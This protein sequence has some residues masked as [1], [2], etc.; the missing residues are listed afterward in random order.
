VKYDTCVPKLI[1]GDVELGNFVLG[2]PD[3]QAKTDFEASRR[4]L[5]EVEGLPLRL[6][7]AID[8]A[9]AYSAGAQGYFGA[10][11]DTDTDHGSHAGS[12]DCG[13]RYLASNG[14][15]IYI[16]LNHLELATPEVLS[17]HEYQALWMA[18]LR[19]AAQAQA[20][21][22]AALPEGQRIVVLA[23]NSDRQDNSYGGHQSFLI[24]RTAWDDMIRQRMLPS[25]FNLMAFQVSSIVYTGQGKVGSENG[26]SPVPFQIAQR[27]DFIETLLGEQTTYHRPLVNT[28]DEPL[29]G[30][31]SWPSALGTRGD[32]YAR[33]HVIFFDT[34]LAPVATF[35]KCGVMQLILTLIEAQRLGESLVL[36][37]PL[38]ALHC[39][40][41]DPDLTVRMPLASGRRVSAVELQMLFLEQAS[42]FEREGGFEGLVPGSARILELWADT[43]CKLE[44]SAFDDLRG[45]LDWVMKRSLIEHS[46]AEHNDWTWESPQVRHLDQVYASLDPRESLFYALDAAGAF[47]RVASAT[48]IAHYTSHPPA[49]TRAWTRAMLLRALPAELIAHVDWDRIDLHLSSNPRDCIRLALADPLGGTRAATQAIFA[50]ELALPNLLM[51]LQQTG[52]IGISTFQARAVAPESHGAAVDEQHFY[53]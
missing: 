23:N 9:A 8:P 46:L 52:A 45:R 5:N 2:G 15:C 37:D 4:L 43:L 24:T 28:R 26:H 19:R 7:Q 35:L 36:D 29:C 32:R 51:A 22:N 6:P 48:E 16:D 30:H 39:W 38:A 25:L 27:A 11:C 1:G 50:Q 53:H 13:R 3:K 17:A 33:L 44:A 10:S 40:S 14:A 41:K 18:M 34:N 31:A 49:D 12:Q 42:A 21:A 20:A 47:E